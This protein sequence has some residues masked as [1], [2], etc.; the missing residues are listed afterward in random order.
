MVTIKKGYFWGK[1][2][3]MNLKGLLTYH[4]SVG[5]DINAIISTSTWNATWQA[6]SLFIHSNA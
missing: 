2:G 3:F 5:I 1:H 6:L 4:I